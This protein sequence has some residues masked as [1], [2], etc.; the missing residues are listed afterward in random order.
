M[1]LWLR[2]PASAINS[3]GCTGSQPLWRRAQ[4]Q[5]YEGGVGLKGV[6]AGAAVMLALWS[7]SPAPDG[8]YPHC[9]TH[10][11]LGWPVET[12]RLR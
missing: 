8:A 1:N 11:T 3:I 10:T 2:A 12:A 6:R 5:R 9:H 4:S 7:G